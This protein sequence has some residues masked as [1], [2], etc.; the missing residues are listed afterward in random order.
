MIMRNLFTIQY[1]L[2]FT[3]IFTSC[4]ATN[5]KQSS[6]SMASISME[7]L[8]D[9]TV[10]TTNSY[11]SEQ[12]PLAQLKAFFLVNFEGSTGFNDFKVITNDNQ[13]FYITATGTREKKHTRFGV[14]L[15][16]SG[17]DLVLQVSNK[18]FFTCIAHYCEAC[19]FKFSAEG[20]ITGCGC[21]ELTEDPPKGVVPCEHTISIKTSNL[22]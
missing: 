22:E 11:A 15:G 21:S 5:K 9:F 12:L 13:H 20:S 16:L 19:D 17:N 8:M 2:I 3:L 18:L 10:A 4:V 14:E 6:R 7:E 1:I